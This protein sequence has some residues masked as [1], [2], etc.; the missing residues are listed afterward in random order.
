[1]GRLDSPRCGAYQLVL[2]PALFWTVVVGMQ[3]NIT[4]AFCG[5]HHQRTAIVVDGQVF[6]L[7][8]ILHFGLDQLGAAPA[9]VGGIA[10][11]VDQV[12]VSDIFGL[13][14]YRHSITVGIELNLRRTSI[15]WGGLDQLGLSPA[16]IGTVLVAPNTVFI[17]AVRV[18]GP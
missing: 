8:S 17:A 18:P 2:A 3:V 7:G 16:G 12:A 10:V 14:P 15:P 6:P 11:G 9:C 13:R 5:P 1:M 4:T